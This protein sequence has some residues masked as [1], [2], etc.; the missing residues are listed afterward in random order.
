MSLDTT[1]LLRTALATGMLAMLGVSG[2][3]R[4]IHIKPIEI[5]CIPYAGCFPCRDEILPPRAA[6]NHRVDNQTFLSPLIAIDEG[7]CGN[8]TEAPDEDFAGIP[9]ARS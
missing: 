5:C 9:Y 3:A 6:G 4:A 1:H 7:R 8:G 2:S